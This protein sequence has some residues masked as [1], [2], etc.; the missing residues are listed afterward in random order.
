MTMEPVFAGIFGVVLGGNHLSTRM[1]LG[2][3]CVLAAMLLAEL[4]AR[5]NSS[6]L[7]T[8][9]SLPV[10]NPAIARPITAEED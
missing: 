1:L 5:S 9:V 3:V 2:A 7:I 6:P 10:Q 4:K 8:P